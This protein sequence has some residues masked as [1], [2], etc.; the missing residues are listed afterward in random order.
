MSC[1]LV[2]FAPQQEV[3]MLMLES[4]GTGD[5]EA[6]T[7]QVESTS[8]AIVPLTLMVTYERF[9]IVFTSPNWSSKPLQITIIECICVLT[10][11]GPHQK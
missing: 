3:K 11:Q 7:P 10:L 2:E 1:G 6:G 9:R 4:L 8:F 5:G